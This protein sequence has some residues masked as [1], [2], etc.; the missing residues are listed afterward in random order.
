M[1]AIVLFG[2][3]LLLAADELP[4]LCGPAACVH[5][6]WA[7]ALGLAFFLAPPPESCGD[8]PFRPFLHGALAAFSAATAVDVALV[9]VG[10]IGERP[11]LPVKGRLYKGRRTALA[12]RVSL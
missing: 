5:G 1:P 11:L 10:C 6:A 12:A 8:S 4:L 2:R 9:V 7:L 3:R